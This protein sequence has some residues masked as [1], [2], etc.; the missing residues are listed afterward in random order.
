MLKR[1]GFREVAS[2]FGHSMKKKLVNSIAGPRSG[3][4]A[5]SGHKGP[6][7]PDPLAK[8]AFDAGE[9]ELRKLG[10][11]MR[12]GLCQELAGIGLLVESFQGKVPCHNSP[13]EREIVSIGE[14]MRQAIRSARRIVRTLEPLETEP[15]ALP[16]A[17]QNLAVDMGD[18]FG[19]ACH[20]REGKSPKNIDHSVAIHLFRVAQIFLDHAIAKGGATAATIALKP[21]KGEVEM[22][23]SVRA[24]G[25]NPPGDL[26]KSPVWAMIEHRARAMGAGLTVSSRGGLC[27]ICR[28]PNR[29]AGNH[30][31]GKSHGRNPSRS[32][33]GKE[34]NISRG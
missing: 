14:L 32:G 6:Q 21:S 25:S 23:V 8:V 15:N 1:Q 11:D 5:A 28:A 27:L 33:R 19:V 22:R 13:C 16:A 9:I 31:V 2:S 30:A 17:L 29:K 3:S 10:R 34:K 7:S 20:F 4:V 18:A 24:A 12:D 26:A